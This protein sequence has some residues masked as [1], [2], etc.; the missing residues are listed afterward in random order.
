MQT[1]ESTTRQERADAQAPYYQPAPATYHTNLQPQFRLQHPQPTLASLKY[2]VAPSSNQ[3]K[4]VP[5]QEPVQV[6]NDPIQGPK[7]FYKP[8]HMIPSHIRQLMTRVYEPQLPYID[9]AAFL[10]REVATQLN[11]DNQNSQ[12]NQKPAQTKPGFLINANVHANYNHQ[13]KEQESSTPYNQYQTK[14][15]GNPSGKATKLA[16]NPRFKDDYTLYA[17]RLNGGVIIPPAFYQVGTSHNEKVATTPAPPISKYQYQ[18]S[19][20]FDND[21]K[22]E[23]T[24]AT[25]LLQMPEML[26]RLLELQAQL[27]YNVIADKIV[28]TPKSIFIPKPLAETDQEGRASYGKYRTKIYILKD[29]SGEA[30]EVEDEREIGQ[31]FIFNILIYK[32]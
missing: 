27:P 12:E 21:N 6:T 28:Y 26:H 16:T 30:Q 3:E 17:N 1:D 4:K 8:Y 13:N 32:Q 9:P 10:Y 31:W 22:K 2:D 23:A 14:Y 20:K 24:A 11:Q 19:V 29:E 5:Q 15:Y 7:V 18:K 25:Q